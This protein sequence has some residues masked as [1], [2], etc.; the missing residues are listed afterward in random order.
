M[1]MDMTKDVIKEGSFS[2]GGI[3]MKRHYVYQLRVLD[4][5]KK[6]IGNRTIDSKMALTEKTFFDHYQVEQPEVLESIRKREEVICDWVRCFYKEE[7]ADNWED[8]I[9]KGIG[10][11]KR[12]EY[13]NWVKEKVSLTT[14]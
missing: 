13:I 2:N 6:Y 4:S 3:K 5:G 8:I 7:D 14:N 10:E 11:G 1:K 9:I 12:P